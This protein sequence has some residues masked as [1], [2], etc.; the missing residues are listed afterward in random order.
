MARTKQ[1]ARRSTNGPAPRLPLGDRPVYY[2]F[3]HG[4]I[5]LQHAVSKE[6]INPDTARAPNATTSD[7]QMKVF[8]TPDVLII[9]LSQL[10]H[11]SLLNAKLVNKTWASL[12]DHVEIQA[13]LFERPRPKGS[14]LYTEA[15]SD[16][17]MSKLLA[18]WPTDREGYEKHELSWQWRQLLVCQPPVEALEIVQE[19]GR[20][21]GGTLEFRTVIPRP[22]GLRM[23]FLYDAIKH[24]HQEERSSA[25]L[26]WDRKTGDLTDDKYYYPDGHGF[27]TLDDKPCVT[28]WGQTSD[29]CGSHGCLTYRSWRGNGQ[30]Q[31]PR[32]IESGG[33]EV[34]FTASEPKLISINLSLLFP[35]DEDENGDGGDEEETVG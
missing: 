8:S 3:K 2:W 17:L 24:S 10:P 16:L 21:V 30:T 1:T 13:S 34:E 14:A 11:S 25:E 32:V 9:I 23:G 20:R 28:I 29:G 4:N 22:G 19:V 18:P 31:K 6:P 5:P 33:E 26:L 12:F 7:A 27:E 15:Y 35:E